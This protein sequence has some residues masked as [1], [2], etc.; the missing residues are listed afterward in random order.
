MGNP[1]ADAILSTTN[2]AHVRA[3]MLMGAMLESGMNANAVGDN[4]K[5]FGPFQIYTVAHPNVSPSQAK[6]PGWAAAFMLPAYQAG[7]NKVA[8]SL[9]TA[10][11]AKAAATAAYYA[12]RPKVM[13]PDSR[14]RSSWSTVQAAMNG[15]NIGPSTGTGG[16]TG[17]GI[18]LASDPLGIGTSIDDAVSSFRKGI[19]ILANMS[20]FFS[21]AVVGGLLVLVGL[22][23]IFRETSVSGA[24]GKVMSAVRVVSPT[25]L[26]KNNG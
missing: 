18:A 15:Q 7:V 14:I 3:A 22:V 4:G 6:N 13:Y 10:D 1:V 8:P 2:D 19:M 26:V 24:G 11:P 20:L 25:R 12:E 9:W 5:S 17:G 16:G 21:A 23:L